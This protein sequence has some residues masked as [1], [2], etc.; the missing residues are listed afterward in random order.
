MKI[1]K[2]RHELYR[3]K[4][5]QE[6]LKVKLTVK[7]KINKEVYCLPFCTF[8]KCLKN[9]QEYDILQ[10]IWVCQY[11]YWI[12]GVRGKSPFT[13]KKLAKLAFFSLFLYVKKK[14]TLHSGWKGRKR[15]CNQGQSLNIVSICNI[16][17]FFSYL[18]LWIVGP[19][20]PHIS[21]SLTNEK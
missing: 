15:K 14:T 8:D 17:L 5:M 3:G 10:D 16:I 9:S 21:L 2:F 11:Q 7:R 13:G 20:D 12:Q 18:H 4:G 1:V 19:S 6:L